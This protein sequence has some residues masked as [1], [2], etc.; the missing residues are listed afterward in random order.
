M[1]DHLP[2][3]GSRHSSRSSRSGSSSSSSRTG[4]QPSP[5]GRSFRDR[6]LRRVHGQSPLATLDGSKEPTSSEECAITSRA[7]RSMQQQQQ[8]QQQ[9]QQQQQQQQQQN[10]LPALTGWQI[11]PGRRLRRAHGHVTARNARQLERADER[12]KVRDHLPCREVDAAAAAAAATAAAAGAAAAAAAAEQAASPHR[13]ADLSGAVGSSEPTATSQTT[14][15]DSKEP[16]SSEECAI[17]FPC[18]EVDAAAAAAEQAASP[19]PAPTGWQ[20]LQGPSAQASPRP[21]RK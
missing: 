9:R 15:D 12:R 5:A 7:G 8:Q 2:Q 19:K 13:L 16:T 6:R 11:L 17:T 18:G 1:R 3:R 4:C 20:I 21:P 10:R 14:V